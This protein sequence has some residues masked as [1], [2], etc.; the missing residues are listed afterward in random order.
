M[1]EAT[2]VVRELEES[3][4]E[5]DEVI[6]NVS[7]KRKQQPRPKRTCALSVNLIDQA[8]LPSG[9]DSAVTEFDDFEDM[10]VLQALSQL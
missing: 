8:A 2:E 7:L 5:I 10:C 4:D 3:N 9:S 1:S 6:Q